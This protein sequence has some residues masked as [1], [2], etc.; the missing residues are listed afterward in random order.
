LDQLE[1]DDRQKKGEV[2]AEAVANVVN[3]EAPDEKG[4]GRD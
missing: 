3:F 2:Q 4:H 1:G